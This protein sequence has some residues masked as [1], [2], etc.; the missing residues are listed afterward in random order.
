MKYITLSTLL[1]FGLYLTGCT[2][3]SQKAQKT[4]DKQM[5]TASGTGTAE[6]SFE[7]TTKN[8]GR[9]AQGAKVVKG[10]IY[11]NIGDEPLIISDA[12]ASC[13]CTVPEYSKEAVKPGE[14]GYIDVEYNS[15]GK[16]AK[17]FEQ[18]VTIMA[19]TPSGSQELKITGEV[20]KSGPAPAE[21]PTRSRNRQQFDMRSQNRNGSATDKHGRSPDDQHYQHNH[22]PQNQQQGQKSQKV[23]LKEKNNGKG[24]ED[25]H[26]RGPNHPH[27]QHNHPP[28]NQQQQKIRTQPKPEGNNSGKD[29]HGR[30][31]DHPHYQHNHPPQDN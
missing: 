24:K 10:F 27:Y 29:K 2:G 8:L 28:K 23:Q 14:K 19:N 26:G 13:G 9:I 15:E 5:T 12:S 11:T 31:P 17:S 25:K 1:A 30:G 16:P 6:F 3:N 7:S 22:P 20:V 4:T 21:Q 18:T